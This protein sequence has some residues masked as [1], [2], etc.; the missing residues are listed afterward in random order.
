MLA[1]VINQSRARVLVVD[2]KLYPEVERVARPSCDTVAAEN[3]LVLPTQGGDVSRA[4]D[5]RACLESEVGPAVEI[6]RRS[7]AVSRRRRP[8]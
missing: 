8:T 1:G 5:L 6:A 2:E 4:V 3:I 7:R